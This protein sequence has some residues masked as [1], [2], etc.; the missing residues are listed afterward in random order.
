MESDNSSDEKGLS[1][2]VCL[3]SGAEEALIQIRLQTYT[4]WQ[5]LY[6]TKPALRVSCPQST[7]FYILVS[8]ALIL[9]AN[10]VGTVLLT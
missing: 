10:T 9:F 8:L 5:N 2:S 3:L 4:L 1:L 7:L 6:F